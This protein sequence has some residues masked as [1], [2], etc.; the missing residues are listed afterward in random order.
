MDTEN[1]NSD[2]KSEMFD[3]INYEEIERP[4]EPIPGET[5]ETKKADIEFIIKLKEKNYSY[6]T[7]KKNTGFI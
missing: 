1:L 5:E 7:A 4:S 6:E 2:E 3:E